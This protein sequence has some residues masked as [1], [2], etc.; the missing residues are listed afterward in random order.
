MAKIKPI[1]PGEHLTEFLDEL[2]ITPYRI[3]K[4]IG[5]G[6]TRIKEIIDGT[7]SI[8]ADTA[9]M[10]GRFFGTSAAF[11]SNL[12]SNYDLEIASKEIAARLAKI[13]PHAA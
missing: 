8:T 11:W 13:T 7:R 10:L 3:A 1:S 2:E 5:V 12:Q 6:Q 9:L 4:E